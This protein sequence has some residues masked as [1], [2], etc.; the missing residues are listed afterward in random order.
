VIFWLRYVGHAERA[1]YEAAGW[2][3]PADLGAHHGRYSLLM[4]WRGAGD[5]PEP[6]PP[7]G[8]KGL[9]VQSK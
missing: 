7:R 5:P 8:F 1:A 3:H 6:A 4:E 9:P 2:V